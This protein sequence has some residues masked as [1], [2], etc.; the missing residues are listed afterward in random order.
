MDN[1]TPIGIWI[2]AVVNLIGS[3][4]AIGTMLY[5]ADMLGPFI[6]LPLVLVVIQ[7]VLIYGL[8]KLKMWAWTGII[9][10]STLSLLS[11]LLSLSIIGIFIQGMIITY[12]AMVKEK[13]E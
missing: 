6:I 12:L 1:R 2:I 13:F 8:V 11:S 4:F 5:M 7:L 10:L 9:I 3:F